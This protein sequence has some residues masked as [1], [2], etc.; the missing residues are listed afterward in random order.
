M[1]FPKYHLK[2]TW[3]DKC[4]KSRFSED[5]STDKMVNRRKHCCNLNDGSFTIII[6]YSGANYVGKSH[7]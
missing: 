6:N 4:L 2:K 5:P 1:Y 7:F 3:L